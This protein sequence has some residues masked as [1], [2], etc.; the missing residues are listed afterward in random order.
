VHDGVRRLQLLAVRGERALGPP[1]VVD[2]APHR[3]EATVA[4][5]RSVSARASQIWSLAARMA[6]DRAVQVLE[7]LVVVSQAQRDPPRRNGVRPRRCPVDCRTAASRALRPKRSGRRRP[8]QRCVAGTSASRSTEPARRAS[9]RAVRSSWI[10][11]SMSPNSAARCRWPAA[12]PRHPGPGDRSRAPPGRAT[13]PRWGGRVP[14][15]AGL[16]A[17]HRRVP[18]GR[19]YP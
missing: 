4:D 3:T 7:R 14:A 1:E 11:A 9:C 18:A 8:A 16:R 17:C 10:A 6:D 13:A 15:G 2:G 12:R 19:P 5:R